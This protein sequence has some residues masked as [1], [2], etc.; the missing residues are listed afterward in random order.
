MPANRTSVSSG[1]PYEPTIGISRAVRIGN[2]IAISGT[3]PL[4]PEG[5]TVEPGNPVAQTRR[6]LDIIRQSV[7]KLGGRLEDIIRTRIYLTRIEDWEYVGRVHGE[8]F[9]NV[10]PASTMVQVNR[11]IDR[12]WLVEIEAD[13]IVND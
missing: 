3:A 4:G 5:T 8:Y 7:E 1:S 13:A 2:V 9:K 10:K 12:E 6:C 11:F